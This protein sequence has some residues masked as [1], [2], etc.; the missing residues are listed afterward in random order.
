MKRLCFCLIMLLLLAVPASYKADIPAEGIYADGEW[1]G[2][3]KADLPLYVRPK[4]TAL[5]SMNAT[6]NPYYNP[7]LEELPFDLVD[8]AVKCTDYQGTQH[9]FAAVYSGYYDPE[10]QADKGSKYHVS[11]DLYTVDHQRELQ[12]LGYDFLLA[13]DDITMGSSTYKPTLLVD[14]Q[15]NT[16]T[17]CM[18]IYKALGQIEYDVRFKHSSDASLDLATSP[19]SQQLHLLYNRE[20]PLDTSEGRTDIWVSRS[21]VDFYREKTITDLAK[22]D[23]TVMKL[24]D[25]TS[26]KKLDSIPNGNDPITLGQFCVYVREFMELYGEPIMSEEEEKILL[27]VY[28]KNL[29]YYVGSTSLYDGNNVLDAIKYLAAKGIIKFENSTTYDFLSPLKIADMYSILAA[30]K[31]RDSRFTFKD[32]E[33]AIDPEL[34]SLGYYDTTLIGEQNPIRDMSFDIGASSYYDYLVPKDVVNVEDDTL[35]L[36]DIC[37]ISTKGKR[38]YV[39]NTGIIILDSEPVY[40]GYIHLKIHAGNSYTKDYLFNKK[41]FRISWKGAKSNQYYELITGGGVYNKNGSKKRLKQTEFSSAYSSDKFLSAKRKEEFLDGGMVPLAPGIPIRF[42]IGVNDSIDKVSFKV[43][44]SDASGQPLTDLLTNDSVKVGDVTISKG[45]KTTTLQYYTVSGCKDLADFRS[46]IANSNSGGRYTE[47]EAFCQDGENIL[48]NYDYLQDVGIATRYIE[49]G[50]DVLLLTTPTNNI[51]L[52]RKQRWIVV[53]NTIYDMPSNSMMYYK[54]DG[55]LFVDY[56]AAM[57]WAGD[58][59]VFQDNN[60][61]ITLSDNTR[62]SAVLTNKLV[63]HQALGN[64][65]LKVAGHYEGV[66]KSIV[67]SSTYPLANYFIYSGSDTDFLFTFKLKDVSI[68]SKKATSLYK[69]D[70]VA[71]TKLKELL[72]V[73]APDSWLVYIYQLSRTSSKKNPPGLTY[74]SEYGYIYTPPDKLDKW[75]ERYYNTCMVNK[76]TIKGTKKEYKDDDIVLPFISSGGK[77]YDINFNKFQMGG[78]NL[79]YGYA[80][81]LFAKTKDIDTSCYVRWRPG[82]NKSDKSTSSGSSSEIK[83]LQAPTGVIN[84]FAGL[85]NMSHTTV[86]PNSY[87]IYLGTMKLSVGVNTSSGKPVQCLGVSMWNYGSLGDDGLK[88]FRILR[89]TRTSYILGTVV[90]DW[91]TAVDPDRV[92]SKEKPALSLGASLVGFDWDKFEFQN[93]LLHA[94][95]WITI[96]T[97][98]VLNF[99]PRIAMFLF[100]TLIALSLITNVKFW[101]LFCDRIFDVYKFLTF[102]RKDVHTV[103]TFTMFWSSILA[104]AVFGLFMDGTILNLIAWFTRFGSAIISK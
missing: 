11:S 81:E 30:V 47:Y 46:R 58:F 86:R 82:D 92:A 71:R 34:D 3:I 68:G 22:I 48:V 83:I 57:G 76:K 20:D 99:V 4:V 69:S 70:K 67:L 74:S 88:E 27:R 51:Y 77:I 80:P 73:D 29:P 91:M 45:L 72:G 38:K 14:E 60:G 26:A 6:L 98:I 39:S 84:I 40:G 10:V 42:C 37:L 61:T 102:Q 53:G 23:P 55:K 85:D 17:A 16:Y 54:K 36:D 56:R 49:L 97:I 103:D 66:T 90:E 78:K 9:D 104:L 18:D 64:S 100:L 89:T 21:N 93:L 8:M 32:V 28:G 35:L 75:R 79:K 44:P 96:A 87:P 24:L 15:I 62:I 94:D 65:S 12:I 63:I 13:S 33:L 2:Y 52:C 31:D 50:D 95:D 41:Y 19:I 43:N 59:Y 25:G 101:I 5:H 7:T 1:E